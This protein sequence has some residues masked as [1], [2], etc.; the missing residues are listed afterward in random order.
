MPNT[1]AAASA[2]NKIKIITEEEEKYYSSKQLLNNYIKEFEKK[3]FDIL[4]PVMETKDAK[5]LS[6]DKKV[7]QDNIDWLVKKGLLKKSFDASE[8]V[9]NLK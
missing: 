4:I 1:A 2:V 6:Q 8:V 9:E 5:F 7:W 3:S